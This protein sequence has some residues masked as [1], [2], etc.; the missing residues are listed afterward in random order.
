MRLTSNLSTAHLWSEY[1]ATSGTACILERTKSGPVC[2]IIRIQDTQDGALDHENMLR[3]RVTGKE[4]DEYNLQ[5]GDILF[6]RAN[7]SIG[8]PFDKDM[9]YDPASHHCI[10]EWLAETGQ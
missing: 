9:L 1:S 5:K 4:F 2:A 10:R 3:Q 7:A 8:D 6:D